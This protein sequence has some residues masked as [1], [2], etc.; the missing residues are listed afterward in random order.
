MYDYEASK[1][2]LSKRIRMMQASGGSPTPYAKELDDLASQ[3][4]G[5]AYSLSE[6]RWINIEDTYNASSEASFKSLCSQ[7]HHLAD[8]ARK[9]RES[10]PNSR[11]RPYIPFAAD[12]LLHIMY[13]CGHP[14]PS[15]YDRGKAVSE[16]VEVCK[17]SGIFLS[18][19]RLRTA[20]AKALKDF[21]PSLISDAIFEILVY[22]Q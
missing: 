5:M 6:P 17:C 7:L 13:Q 4:D 9:E 3:L 10:L 18:P 20:L 8:I 11:Q 19:G 22:H 16:L 12:G 15:L 21:E 14:L 1:T 2:N